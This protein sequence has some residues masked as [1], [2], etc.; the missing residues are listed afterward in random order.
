M[1][2]RAQIHT[3]RVYEDVAP[4]DGVRYLVDRLWPR[5]LKKEELSLDAWLKDVAPSDGLRRWY[6]HDAARWEEFQKRY[7]AE[8]DAKQDAWRH[9]LDD[10]K[11]G[12]VTLLFAARH[13]E[14]NNAVALKRYLEAKCGC[15]PPSRH[16]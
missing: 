12:T 4:A 6:G 11:Q 5:G 13:Q 16:R 2:A 3:K 15:A 10:A 1:A 7:S 14:R 9:I 8:L